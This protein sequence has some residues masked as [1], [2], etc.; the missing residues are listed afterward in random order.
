MSREEEFYRNMR[1]Y[2]DGVWSYLLEHCR[3]L[4]SGKMRVIFDID[5]Q[6]NF[7]KRVWVRYKHIYHREDPY[8]KQKLITHK[9]EAFIEKKQTKKEK[10]KK[11]KEER[12]L[13]QNEIKSAIEKADRFNK[14]SPFQ[15]FISNLFNL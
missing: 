11:E 10:Y 12:R 7:E 5:T 4:K 3:V 8:K 1:E 9:R 15:K 6:D 13:K 14:M 2:K